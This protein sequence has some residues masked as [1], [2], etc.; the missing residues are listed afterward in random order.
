MAMDISGLNKA[1]LNTQKR[2]GEST[3]RI[4]DILARLSNVESILED[5][6]DNTDTDISIS[7]LTI[8]IN[9]LTNKTNG[10]NYS[11]NSIKNNTNIYIAIDDTNPADI[12]G[13][14]W[15]KV[16]GKFLLSSSNN[17][18]AGDTGGSLS[19]S[20]TLDSG[21]AMIETTNN[22]LQYKQYSN[23]FTPD[24]AIS[25]T[26]T[27][28][29]NPAYSAEASTALGGKTDTDSTLPPYLVVNVWKRI[30]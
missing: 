22:D 18:K 23:G 4:E 30:S 25:G 12:F 11:I 26:G 29:H 6:S 1:I 24:W 9:A 10:L 14:T 28:G 17:I 8:K 13:G 20:H 7:N 3:Y 15:E 27:F 16:E 19:H 5:I 21:Y 2:L